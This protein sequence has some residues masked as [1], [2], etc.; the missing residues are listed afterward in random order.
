MCKNYSGRK[1][2]FLKKNCILC[3][4]EVILMFFIVMLCFEKYFH[5][6]IL[7]KFFKRIF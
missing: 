1:F 2:F 4:F 5:K 6:K 3:F 7:T